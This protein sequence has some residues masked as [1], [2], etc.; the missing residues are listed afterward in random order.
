MIQK[1]GPEHCSSVCAAICLHK[2]WLFCYFLQSGC[3]VVKCHRLNTA[4]HFLST[5][6]R[7]DTAG[8]FFFFLYFRSPVS[9]YLRAT[10]SL[11]A[12]TSYYWFLTHFQTSW[13]S[14]IPHI[15]FIL[16]ETFS[17]P[18]ISF[19]FSVITSLTFLYTLFHIQYSRSC[20]FIHIQLSFLP[21]FKSICISVVSMQEV[22]K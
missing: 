19:H 21:A 13:C 14:L 9:S 3:K 2:L 18:F 7:L 6:K 10:S 22:T 16:F 1:H 12:S 11:R 5:S 15:R 8:I 4:M 20:S 17:V